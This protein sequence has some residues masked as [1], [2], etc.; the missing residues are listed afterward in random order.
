M[1]IIRIYYNS[2]AEKVPLAGLDIHP[3]LLAIL[4]EMGI[5]EVAGDYIETRYIKRLYKIMRLRERLGINL[6]GAAVIV[7]LLE[8]IEEL[9]EEIEYLKTR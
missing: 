4:Q 2:S 5:V 6:N 3:D 7:E 9:E 8:R 1:S